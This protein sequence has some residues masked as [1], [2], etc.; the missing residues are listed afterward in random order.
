MAYEAVI[1]LEVH[2]QLSTKSKIFCGCRTKFGAKPNSQACPVCLGL[3]GALPVLNKSAVE[4]AL[5]TALSLNCRIAGLSRFA[6]KN[7]YYPDLPKNYQ[8]SQYD[9]PLSSGGHIEIK[10]NGEAK[11]IGITRV[12]LEED[13]GKL[14]HGEELESADSSFVDYNRTGVSL[15]EVVSEPDIST[16][17]EA[18]AYLATLKSILQY[19]EVSDCNME[20]GSLRCDANIS[21]RFKGEKEFGTK[22]ELKNMNSF[23]G[24]REALDYEIARQSKLLAE[25]KE[26]VQETRLWEAKKGVTISMRGKEEAQDYRYFPEPDL[27]PLTISQEWITEIKESLPELPEARERRFLAQYKIP[28]YDAGV[29]TSSKSLADYFEECAK[30]YPKFKIVSNW[31]MGEVLGSLKVSNIEIKDCLIT[32]EYLVE[33][34][35][36]IDKG[37]ISGKIAKEVFAEMFKTGKRAE[38]IVEEKGLTQITSEEELSQVLERIIKENAQAVKEYQEGKERA[39]GHLI[40]QVMRLTQGKANPQLVN[41]LL[42]E[43]LKIKR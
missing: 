6:R 33:M 19:I 2:V 26:V 35:R 12:H 28:E 27:V 34:L 41:K 8:I 40:G 10:V 25:G 37:T 30:L 17:E 4:Y 39:L 36:L 13:A 1:G 14:I 9:E 3:P 11:K 23:K 38:E 31:I 24:V 43:K 18:Y 5:R 29:L 32:P 15:M 42:K 20:E 21:L 7:Y 16:P 22:A